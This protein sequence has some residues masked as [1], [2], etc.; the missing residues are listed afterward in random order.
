MG[1]SHSWI[2]VS[3]L[4]P[5]DAVATL[6]AEVVGEV[7]AR[8]LPEA[9][10]MGVLPGG[11]LLVLSN[12]FDDAFKGRLARLAALGPA[13][14]CAV[15]E[16]VMYAEARGYDAGGET[17]RAVRDP[18]DDHLEVTGAPPAALTAIRDEA[19]RRQDADEAT[20]IDFLFS[21]PADMAAAICGYQLGV[22]EPEGFRYT[23][24]R[25]LREAASGGDDGKPGFF[26]RLFGLKG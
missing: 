21:A 23:E 12:D 17:W 19:I 11:W 26:A 20:G 24:L 8:E 3:G 9:L 7:D 4:A 15:E 6:G 14:A 22:Q 10:G 2:A 25:Y 13:V 16:H 1:F 18:D 5:D